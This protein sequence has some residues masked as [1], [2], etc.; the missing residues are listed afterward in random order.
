MQQISDD[1]QD[2][3]AMNKVQ[4]KKLA[5]LQFA[6]ISQNHRLLNSGYHSKAFFRADALCHGHWEGLVRKR[7]RPKDSST[8]WVD[9]TSPLQEFSTCPD[10]CPRTAS[11]SIQIK[12]S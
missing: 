7:A 9:T 3:L 2:G 1:T 12:V 5:D 11:N 4:P 6:L 10:I 8:Y